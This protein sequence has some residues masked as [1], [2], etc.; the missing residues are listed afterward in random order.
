MNKSKR[1]GFWSG[2]MV[3]LILM[4]CPV[5]E[6]M[7]PEALKALGVAL[8]MA[9]WWV[10]ECIP[11]YA[12][13]FV[14]IAL[15]PLLGILDASTTTENYGHNYVLMLLG[16]FFLA[17][18]IEL[19]GLHKRVALYIISKLGTSRRRIILSFMIATAFLSLW[20]ANV[21]V[22][23]LMLPIALA[24]VDKEEENKERNPKFG[25]ALMLAIAYAASVGG[26]GSLIGTPPNMVFAGVFAKT[27]PDLPEI[28]FL[29]WMKLGTPIVIILLPIIWIY[30]IKYFKIS[31]N[32][33]GSKE[34]INEEIIA[35]GKL[36]KM[37]KRVFIVFLFT[38]IGW[39]F[40]RDIDLD[41]FIIPGWSSLLGIADYVHDST[42]AI[43]SAVLLF[44]IPSGNKVASKKPTMLLD[45]K[46][47]SKVPWGVVMIVGGGYAIADSFNHTGLATFLGSKL[48]F[49][50][51]YPVIII[52]VIVILLMIFI[53]EINSNT[54]TANIFLPVLAAMAVA[55]QINPLLLMIPATFACSFSFMLPSGTGTN[56]VIFGSNRVTIA[57][58]AKCGLGLNFLCVILLTMLMYMYVLPVLSL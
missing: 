37:E 50:S 8:L 9:I 31:G 54:A 34:V 43:I 13:A 4:I 25:L 20:I 48:S 1:I 42:V 52:L 45:W 29:E 15:F 35:I 22:V 53:T 40:R 39:I 3:L 28:D 51:N 10:S 58:M 6:G 26:T 5:P 7:Q 21:A 27:F 17:K 47:A 32:F 41:G 30:I 16:G 14:P 38:A 36:S 56:A 57:E 19:S 12:T 11:I 23:L 44:A 33:A 18:S 55:G 49:I 46:S 2:I 24:I